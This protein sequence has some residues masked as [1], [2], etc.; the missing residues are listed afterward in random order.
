MKFS[1]DARSAWHTHPKGQTLIVTNGTIITATEDGV[2]QVAKAGDVISCPPNLK[3]FHG[4]TVD[5]K[6][7]HIALT[8]EI[9]GKNVLW[10]EKVSDKE[11]EEALKK[12]NLK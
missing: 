12:A 2:V 5:E 10:L 6:G 8:S 7:E 9:D 3:H 11:Y 4:A 1:P